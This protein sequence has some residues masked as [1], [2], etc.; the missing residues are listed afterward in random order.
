M[1]RKSGDLGIKNIYVIIL[2]FDNAH[3]LTYLSQ[4]INTK[5]SESCVLSFAAFTI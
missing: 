1:I 4:K 2:D 3:T 5:N